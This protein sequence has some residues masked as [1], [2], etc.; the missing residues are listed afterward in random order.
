MPITV[1]LGLGAALGVIGPLAEKF[2]NPICHAVALVFSGG[3]SWAC[4]AFL[5]GYFRRSKI[6]S[7][8]LASSALAIGVVVYYLFKF[9]SPAAPIG[10]DIAGASGEGLTSRILVWGIAAF[11]FGAPVG[12][13]GN[14]ARTPGITGLPFRLLVPLIAFIETSQRL[15]VE[16]DS[17]GL[18]V[19]ITWNAIRVVAA[20][21][22]VA[23]VGHTVW[24]WR[25]RRSQPERRAEVG[26]SP[27]RL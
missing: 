6:E 17:Q 18:I 26:A 20:V 24:S 22:A 9:L 4:F 27:K 23:L 25:A 10:M 5:V 16:A 14:L 3:W 19:A 2:D 7:A 8:L 21:V 12:L 1:A 13:V 15:R 11:A